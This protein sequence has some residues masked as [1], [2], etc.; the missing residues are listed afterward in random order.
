[1]KLFPKMNKDNTAL[2]VIDVV[3]GCAHEKCETPEWGATFKKIRE[4]TS[5]LKGFIEEYR[6]K[7]GSE[8]IFVNCTSWVKGQIADNVAE[9]YETYPEISYFSDDDSGFEGKWFGIEPKEG[10][11]ILTKNTTSAFSNPKLDKTLKEKGIQYLVVVGVFGDG[12]VMSTIEHGFGIGY[13]FVLLGDYIETTD[14]PERQELQHLL[15]T[16]AWPCLIGP[17]MTGDEFLE[18][19]KG[20]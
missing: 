17:V 9:L 16:T 14:K 5:N 7:V 19:W 18:A 12:C 2:L 3:N 15:K 8:V 1:M 20:K 6:S 11:M 10:D 13:S 4:M